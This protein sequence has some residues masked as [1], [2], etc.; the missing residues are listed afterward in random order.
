MKRESRGQAKRVPF[1]QILADIREEDRPLKR[2]QLRRLSDMS[3]EDDRAFR[4]LWPDL[5]TARRRQMMEW[6][7]KVCELDFAVDFEPLLQLGLQDPDA[8]VRLAAVAGLWDNENAALVPQLLTLLTSDPEV[9]VR[10]AVAQTLGHYVLL[11]EVGK[12]PA[13]LGERMQTRL[14]AIIDRGD[15]EPVDVRRRAIEALSYSSHD[16]VAGLISEAYASADPGLRA[17]AVFAMGRTADN[18][19]AG[20][21][22]QELSSGSSSMR[23]EA[24]RSAGELEMIDAVPRL[25]EMME[26]DDSPQVQRAATWAL[27]EIGGQ[28]AQSALERVLASPAEYLHDVADDAL[29]T[30]VMLGDSLELPL[31]E[32]DEA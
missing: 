15:R 2:S 27:G 6:L 32:L 30:L 7:A 23:Y 24:A 20:V 19:W 22:Q 28:A 9:Q 18:R 10:S 3:T 1:A 16:R 25:I 31:F 5:P 26:D 17:S 13:A 21:V 11:A 14:L 8:E 29:H 4:E 12:L